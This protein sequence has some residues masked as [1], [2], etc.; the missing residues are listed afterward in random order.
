MQSGRTFE[1]SCMYGIM[2]W[3]GVS[4]FLSMSVNLGL[5][6]T[7]GIALPLIS[8]GG[9]NLLTNACAIGILIRMTRTLAREEMC[10][11]LE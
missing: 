4:I 6:P 1:A 8:Y 10:T 11:D 2:I 3:W 9:S 7:K 5:V